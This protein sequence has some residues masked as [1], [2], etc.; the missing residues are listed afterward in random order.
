MMSIIQKAGWVR[1]NSQASFQITHLNGLCNLGLEREIK[2]KELADFW[3]SVGSTYEGCILYTRQLSL[4][5]KVHMFGHNFYNKQCYA[6]KKNK[7]RNLTT[8]NS[9]VQHL[10]VCVCVC[11]YVRV[12]P[13]VL[14]FSGCKFIKIDFGHEKVGSNALVNRGNPCLAGLL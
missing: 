12:R 9:W 11:V 6:V 8:L 3:E 5:F 14:S 7:F 1:K 4:I 2:K 13:C 10:C